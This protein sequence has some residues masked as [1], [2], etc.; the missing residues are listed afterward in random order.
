MVEQWVVVVTAMAAAASGP[1]SWE[2]CLA[3]WRAAGFITTC[4]AADGAIAAGIAPRLESAA[5]PVAP[6]RK[7]V[8]RT[9][10]EEIMAAVTMPVAVASLVATTAGAV[11]M[12]A[13]AA[14]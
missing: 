5:I 2:G 6:L 9:E 10:A 4:S 13:G 12:S 7:A 8:T 14:L 1:A 3:L 11:E